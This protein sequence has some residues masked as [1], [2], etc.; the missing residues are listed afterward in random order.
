MNEKLNKAIKIL[1]DNNQ[2]HIIP[3]LNEGRNTELL[4][5]VLTIDFDELKSLYNKTNE[6][7]NVELNEIQPIQAINPKKL[8]NI[9]IKEIEQIGED[10]IKQNKFAVTTMA[11]RTRNKTSDIQ[12]QKEH[13]KLILMEKI[14]IY[15]KLLCRI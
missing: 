1:E 14:S 13:I 11:G 7:T 9:Q 8:S 12:E 10:I 2:E 6:K 15:L 3:F 5:Q 4:N